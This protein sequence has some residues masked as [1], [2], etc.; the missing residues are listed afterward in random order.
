MA[1]PSKVTRAFSGHYL[2]ID[3]E[4]WPGVGTWEILRHPGAAAVLPVT[5]SGDAIFVKQF[6]A[7][8]RDRLVEVPA[9]LLDVEGEDPLTCAARELFEETGYR[10]ET[11]EFLG[12]YYSSAGATDEYV[13]LFWARVADEPEGPPEEGIEV[14]RRPLE[15]MLAAART[16]RV[17][18]AKTALALLLFAGLGFEPGSPVR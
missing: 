12:G 14:V 1:E 5:A 4:E 10:H 7:A 2:S 3:I 9:G 15:S 17:R 8:I 16:G 13:H 6:R 18:D 11:I